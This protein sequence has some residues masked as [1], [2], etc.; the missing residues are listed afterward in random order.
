LKQ[1][2]RVGNGIV[3][4]QETLPPTGIYSGNSSQ[5]SAEEFV[6]EMGLRTE[7]RAAQ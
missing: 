6:V 7:N 1:A 3:F 5:K 2:A 4:F